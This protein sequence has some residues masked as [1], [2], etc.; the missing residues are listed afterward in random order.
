MRELADGDD[1]IVPGH[2][3]TV[4]ERFPPVNAALT[5]IACRLA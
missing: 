5:G 2:D 4:L 1:L 3:P